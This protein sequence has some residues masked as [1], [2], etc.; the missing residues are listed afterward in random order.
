ME[1]QDNADRSDNIGLRPTTAETRGYLGDVKKL[2]AESIRYEQ[3]RIKITQQG[4]RSW[5]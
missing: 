1:E 2:E 4:E 5:R 3:S